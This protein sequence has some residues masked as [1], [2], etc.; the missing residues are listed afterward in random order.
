MKHVYRRKLLVTFDKLT[1]ER[2]ERLKH[3]IAAVGRQV[4]VGWSGEAENGCQKGGAE[5]AD[6]KEGF[7]EVAAEG[8]NCLYHTM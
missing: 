8:V 7:V 6:V 5:K 3:R 4:V 1:L 2:E